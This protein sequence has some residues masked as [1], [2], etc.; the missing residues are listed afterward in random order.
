VGRERNGGKC[1]VDCLGYW[2]SMVNGVFIL[3]ILA[4]PPK[5]LL[6]APSSHQ[7]D[8][9]RHL[10]GTPNKTLDGQ[11]NSSQARHHQG[12]F[13][14]VARCGQKRYLTPLQLAIISSKVN[15]MGVNDGAKVLH[16][17]TDLSLSDVAAMCRGIAVERG[18]DKP[19][20]V[21]DC[22]N[23][24]YVF[25]SK[26]SSIVLSA[27]ANHLMKWAST[28]IVMVP[29]C[30]G[31]RPVCKQATNQRI[32]ASEKNRIKAFV[33]RKQIREAKE[34]L[35]REKF[36]QGERTALSKEISKMQ[37]GCKSCETKS[38]VKIPND[39]AIGL[40]DELFNCGGHTAI[41]STGGY[42]EEV[43][44][45]TFQADSHMAKQIINNK[46][47]MAMTT[48]SDIPIICG[49]CCIAIKS[50][51]KGAFTV[52]SVSERTLRQAMKH[53]ATDSKAKFVQA[54]NPVFDGVK[55]H[56]LR[57]MSRA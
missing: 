35:I 36:N 1:F 57:A 26:S 5:N 9:H 44:V 21:A 41:P 55:N 18:V 15:K 24:V 25:F 40:K 12:T 4:R 14:A 51:T 32:A 50:F 7:Q 30:D 2:V 23:I 29:V 31:I 28:G 54:E 10:I 6:F 45:S 46:A 19:R 52:V 39:Y 11:Q 13:I 3:Q 8:I 42:V 53:I 43:V 33:L 16:S 20:V 22:N 38:T 56:R 34:R 17:I 27:V 47:V 37:R 48:D 49:D